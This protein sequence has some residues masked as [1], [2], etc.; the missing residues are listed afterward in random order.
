[1]FKKDLERRLKGIFDFKKITFNAPNYEALDQG[2]MYV[3]VN[4]VKARVGA[5]TES[6]RVLGELIVFSQNNVFPFGYIAKR[7]EQARAEFTRPLFFYD[8]DK[9][10]PSPSRIQ[11]VFERHT[12]F[13]F[14]YSGQYDPDHG[15]LT[16]IAFPE[17]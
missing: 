10:E 13:V 4:D 1:M 8:F 7:V 5:G 6:A 12:S 3:K 2:T 15:A 14:L 17:E 11:N 9:D 16:S